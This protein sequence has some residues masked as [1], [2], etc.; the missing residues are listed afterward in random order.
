MEIGDVDFIHSTRVVLDY[1]GEPTVLIELVDGQVV[2]IDPETVVVYP[3]MDA[4]ADG[5][6][7]DAEAIEL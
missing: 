5:D 2:C 1:S 7:D 6:D 4:A 3:D